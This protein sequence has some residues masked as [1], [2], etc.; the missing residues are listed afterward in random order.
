MWPILPSRRSDTWGSIAFPVREDSKALFLFFKRPSS[1]AIKLYIHV[2]IGSMVRH[3]GSGNFHL[4]LRRKILSFLYLLHSWSRKEKETVSHLLQF[5]WVLEM[6]WAQ[7]PTWLCREG[8]LTASCSQIYLF[9][10]MSEIKWEKR[11]HPS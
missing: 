4:V 9:F 10:F 11:L 5:L 2:G 8:E 1:Q 6:Q 3:I 7:R